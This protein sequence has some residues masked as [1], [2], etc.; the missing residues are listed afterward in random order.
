MLWCIWQRLE[1]AVVS[2]VGQIRDCVSYLYSM[3]G[4]QTPL[5]LCLNL[6]IKEQKN[7]YVYVLYLVQCVPVYNESV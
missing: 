5:A 4:K 6:V 3:S 7:V 2:S 1:A